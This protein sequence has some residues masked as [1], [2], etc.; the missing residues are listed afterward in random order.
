MGSYLDGGLGFL[1]RWLLRRHLVACAACFTEYESRGGLKDLVGEWAP[2]PFPMQVRARV[3]VAVS[4]SLSGR[5]WEL[6]TMRARNFLRPVAVPAVGGVLSAVMLF[7]TFFSDVVL[8][9]GSFHDDVPLTYLTKAW[10]TE[11]T[12]AEIPGFSPDHDVT[13][14]VFIDRAGRVYD[15]RMLPLTTLSAA[16]GLKIESQVRNILLTTQFD[17]ATKF[18]QPVFGRVLVGFRSAAPETVYG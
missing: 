7:A 13:V 14:E 8:I 15:V 10:I 9:R 5:S 18:G 3:L 12:L 1:S 16:A 17:P 11:P 2:V 4:H 6:L